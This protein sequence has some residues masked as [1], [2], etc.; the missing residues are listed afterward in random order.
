MPEEF[1]GETFVAFI[2]ISGFKKSKKP[3]MDL[4][5]FYK[6]GY[7]ALKVRDS[8]NGIFVSDCGII[9]VNMNVISKDEGLIELLDAVKEINEKVL[10]DDLLLTT[11]IAYG[12][13]VHA[14]KNTF[15]RIEKN[16]FEGSAYLEAYKD[17][18]FCK[19][20]IKP[21][22]CRLISNGLKDI[23]LNE[24]ILNLLYE[25]KNQN[26]YYFCWMLEDTSKIDKFKKDYD[27][28]YNSRY[29]KIKDLLKGKGD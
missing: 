27:N 26:R 5:N 3:M 16:L 17:N 2:D 20:K 11:S 13:F 23:S 22:Q 18:A 15:N 29:A 25:E 24:G 7:N 10:V 14:N 21:G 6:H 28:V 4:S 9:Y 1:K 19:P 8:L 12:Y